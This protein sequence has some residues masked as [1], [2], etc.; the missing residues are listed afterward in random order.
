MNIGFMNRKIVI[1]QPTYATD[2]QNHQYVSGWTTYKSIW[3]SWVHAV[4]TEV[5]D[6]GQMVAKDTYDWRVR[7]LD[8]PDLKMDM[9]ISYNSEYYSIVS[10]KELGVREAY[11]LITIRRDNGTF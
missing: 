3:A 1:E 2:A 8:V 11:Q 9:R 7:F 10:I 4:S 5:F 6:S